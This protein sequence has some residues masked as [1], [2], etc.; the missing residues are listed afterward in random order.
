MS[1]P[2]VEREPGRAS[3]RQ[4]TPL[5]RRG[6]VKRDFDGFKHHATFLPFSLHIIEL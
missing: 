6:G 1:E 5:L 4:E 3:V 2:S